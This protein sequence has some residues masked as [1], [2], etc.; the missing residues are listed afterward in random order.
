M[1]SI[2]VTSL[3][4]STVMWVIATG[5]S[6]HGIK[7][8]SPIQS[9]HN[10]QDDVSNHQHH[11]CLL[12]R[13][14]RRRSKKASKLRVTGGCFTNVSRALQ[15]NLSK[16]VY[17]RNRTSYENF[18]LKLCTCAQ[19]HALGTRT[20][21]QHEILTINVISGIVYFRKIIL[22]SSRNVSEIT[23][24]SLWGEFTGNRFT[25][26][27]L[28][29]HSMRH[30]TLSPGQSGSRFADDILKCIFINE[31]FCISFRI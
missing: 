21:F 13:L 7:S 29:T 20:R 14:S 27:G 6:D 30:L 19:S 1:P 24:W 31:D 11:H 3:A 9:R 15:Y 2:I 4:C 23:P 26:C 8:R 18:K 22:E 10:D 17:C 28:V 12:N 25:H 5:I 16:F